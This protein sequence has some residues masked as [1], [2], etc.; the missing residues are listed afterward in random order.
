MD[1]T[2]ISMAYNLFNVVMTKTDLFNLKLTLSIF[3][4]A[5]CSK[6]VSSNTGFPLF[7]E[8]NF[9]QNVININDLLDA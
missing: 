9:F 4:P 1:E 6:V 5:N 3:S 7:L 8:F 2:N